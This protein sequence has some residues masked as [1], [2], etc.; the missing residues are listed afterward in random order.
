MDARG[1]KEAMGFEDDLRRIDEH[2]A[3]ARRLVQRQ[4]GLVIRLRPDRARGMRREYFGY[5]KRTSGD[6]KNTGTASETSKTS[7]TLH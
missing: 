4:K 2:I 3:E 6:W 7:G 1:T 5:W